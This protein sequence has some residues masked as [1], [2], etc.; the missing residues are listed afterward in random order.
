LQ[1]EP[2]GIPNTGHRTLGADL[3]DRIR[4]LRAQR[5][6]SLTRMSGLCGVS[7]SMLSEIERGQANPTVAVALAIAT[8]FSMSLDE[9]VAATAPSL[10]EVIRGDDAYYVYR[11]DEDCRIRTLSPLTPDR[12]LEFYEVVFEPGGAL[13]SAPHFA[14]TREYL[15]VRSGNVRLEVGAEAVELRRGDSVAYPADVEHAIVNTGRAAAT[16]YLIDTVP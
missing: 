16:V 9:L 15:T 4:A 12:G 13:R 11:S 7:R 14:G 5:G 2:S 8:A 3:S 6:W 10:L 1:D